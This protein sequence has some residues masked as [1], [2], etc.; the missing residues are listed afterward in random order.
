MTSKKSKEKGKAVKKNRPDCYPWENGF[1]L[2]L[3]IAVPLWQDSDFGNK[4]WQIN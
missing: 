1:W 2:E 3:L 4:T